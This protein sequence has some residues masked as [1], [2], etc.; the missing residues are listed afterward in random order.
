VLDE[1]TSSVDRH[2]DRLLHEALN[3]AYDDATIVKI[4]HRLDTIIED[5]YI[6]V[7]RSGKLLEFGSPAELIRS[8]GA[9]KKM[10]EDTARSMAAELKKRAYAAETRIHRSILLAHL[11]K[12]K[13]IVVFIVI[14]LPC[15]I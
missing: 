5:D 6:L 15:S 13:S 9:F 12:K 10:V 2:T 7:L 14:A 1:A 4:A 11:Q 3:K 8:G